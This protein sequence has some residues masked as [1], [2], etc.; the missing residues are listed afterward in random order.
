M[1]DVGPLGIDAVDWAQKVVQL[2]AGE[3]L[4]TS[5][6]CDGVQKGYDIDLNKTISETVEVPVIASGGAGQ[7]NH[8][9]DVVK[10]G[11]AKCS[12]CGINISFWHL[13]NT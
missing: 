12:S 3:I 5:M 1:E 11:K 10:E 9:V 6:D 7:L 2:G 8:L 13:H 4:L